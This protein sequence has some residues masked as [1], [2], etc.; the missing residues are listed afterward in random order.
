MSKS[1]SIEQL[2]ATDKVYALRE[3]SQN[4]NVL[5]ESL[6]ISKVTLYT[7]LKKSNWKK[8][9]ISLINTLVG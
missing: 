1:A 8:T 7:R 2:E 6:G 4:D 3:L 9:E 5:A